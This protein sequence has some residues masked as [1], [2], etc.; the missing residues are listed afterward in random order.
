[1][2]RFS[3]ISAICILT[4][5]GGLMLASCD[6]QGATG[7]EEA[8]PT[9]AVTA[10]PTRS[11]IRPEADLAREEPEAEPLEPLALTIAMPAGAELNAAAQAQLERVLASEQQRLGG[12]VVLR[13][14]T[15]SAG[16]DAA[17]LRAAERRANAVAEWLTERGVAEERI[18]V[19]ALGEQNPVQPNANPDGTPNEAGRIANRRVELE[20]DL[21][22]DEDRILP[23]SRTTEATNGAATTE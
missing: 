20:V 1:M 22:L 8:A 14:H 5:A 3:N 9:P 21:P 4:L 10:S 19:I 7:A 6:R 23:T 18:T 11:I 13:G 2:I 17:N 12:P 15:D 16:S